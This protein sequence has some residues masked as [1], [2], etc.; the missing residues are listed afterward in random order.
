LRAE[1]ESRGEQICSLVDRKAVLRDEVERLRRGGSDLGK[2][3]DRHCQ[4]VLDAT[5]LHDW[6]DEDGDGDWGAVWENLATLRPRAEA[7][8]AKVARVEAL[9]V[10][11]TTGWCACDADRWPCHTARALADA[12]AEPC[13]SC[14]RDLTYPGQRGHECYTHAERLA[15]I[16]AA[17]GD[18]RG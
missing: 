8:E 1:V 6:I 14:E 11:T 9:H 4:M 18:G 13:P 7:A 12:P 5:G 16:R 3:I 17:E 2:I 15:N 10:E